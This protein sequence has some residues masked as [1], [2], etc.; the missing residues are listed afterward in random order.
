MMQRKY[1]WKSFKELLVFI[2]CKIIINQLFISI[3]IRVHVSGDD[4]QQDGQH[5]V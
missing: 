4:E 3:I 2:Q 5:Q 1:N